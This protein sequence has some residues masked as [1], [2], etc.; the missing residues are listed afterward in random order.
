MPPQAA[1]IDYLGALTITA[2]LISLVFGLLRAA[3]HPWGSPSVLVPLLI[4]VALLLVTLVVESRVKAP[5]VP[6]KF[7]W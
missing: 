5:L 6:L 1:G 4:G 7:L 2:G 3:S